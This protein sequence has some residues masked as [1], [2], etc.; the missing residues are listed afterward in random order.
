MSSPTHPNLPYETQSSDAL[1]ELALDLRW[2]WN[3]GAEALWAELE[4]ELWQGL[5]NP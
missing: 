3:D 5:G 2:T 1:T 4:P